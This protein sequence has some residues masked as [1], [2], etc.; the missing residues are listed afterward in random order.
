MI[1]ICQFGLGCMAT[2]CKRNKIVMFDLHIP[3]TII[4]LGNHVLG[5]GGWLEK[6]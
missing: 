1:K 5:S 3:C 2:L 6:Y 4:E